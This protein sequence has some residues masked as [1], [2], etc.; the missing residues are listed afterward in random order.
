MSGVLVYVCF[1]SQVLHMQVSLL[2]ALEKLA[3]LKKVSRAEVVSWLAGLDNAEQEMFWETLV[4]HYI[5]VP[6][7]CS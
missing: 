6:S 7:K 4:S 1:S 2:P 5:L 3:V